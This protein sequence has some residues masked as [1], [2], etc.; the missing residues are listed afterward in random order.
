M[1]GGRC[2]WCRQCF[3]CYGFRVSCANGLTAVPDLRSREPWHYCSYSRTR[4]TLLSSWT[5][6]FAE[7]FALK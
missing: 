6:F 7:D 1:G 4:P 3:C 5:P 2:F